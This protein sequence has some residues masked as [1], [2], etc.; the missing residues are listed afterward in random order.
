M[1]DLIVLVGV[2]ASAAAGAS[3]SG[4]EFA[5]PGDWTCHRAKDG[6]PQAVLGVVSNENNGMLLVRCT[7]GRPTISLKWG[8]YAGSHSTSVTMRL[9]QGESALSSWQPSTDRK[10]AQY[11]G[12]H[13][14]YL[15]DL[16]Q[17]KTL[18]VRLTPYPVTPFV[19]VANVGLDGV[20]HDASRKTIPP[21]V[22]P[23]LEMT[24]TLAGL[25]AA[26]LEAQGS[27][28]PQ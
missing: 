25:G 2:V 23:P 10:E 3:V 27:C 11:P 8:N 26:I 12:D 19:P 1:K 13:A 7:S 6:S 17:R 18:S 14:A 5:R 20:T 21:A 22:D 4:G 16:Q 24:F 15:R 28:G 9:D